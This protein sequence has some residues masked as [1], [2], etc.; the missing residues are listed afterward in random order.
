VNSGEPS[1]GRKCIAHAV[2]RLPEIADGQQVSL[3]SW[4]YDLVDDDLNINRTAGRRTF[5]GSEMATQ[6][7]REAR[8]V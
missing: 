7:Q 5:Q 4:D 2:R 3:L 6:N 8:Y 1:Y